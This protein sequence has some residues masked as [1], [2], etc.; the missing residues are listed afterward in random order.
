[1]ALV[2]LNRLDESR[3]A[4]RRLMEAFPTYTLT[5]QRQIN[6]WLEKVFAER[7]VAALGVPE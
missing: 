7:Y 2:K 5:L 4:A 6:P 3:S 1:M